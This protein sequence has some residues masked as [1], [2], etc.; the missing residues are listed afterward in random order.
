M[1]NTYSEG[2]SFQIQS[3]HLRFYLYQWSSIQHI[4]SGCDP[5]MVQ[6]VPTQINTKGSVYHSTFKGWTLKDGLKTAWWVSHLHLLR[7]FLCKKRM[8]SRQTAV[9][10]G[11]GTKPVTVAK[12]TFLAKSQPIETVRGAR[13]T[14][15]KSGLDSLCFMTH[16]QHHDHPPRS[17]SSRKKPAN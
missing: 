14:K 3:R 6:L 9:R 7:C 2:I 5:A 8:E 13:R 10:L 12:K 15:C 17:T 16:P 11:C 4:A 1:S